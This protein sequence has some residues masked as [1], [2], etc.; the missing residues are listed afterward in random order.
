MAQ[1][2]NRTAVGPRYS[3]IVKGARKSF[4][5]I[6]N[7]GRQLVLALYHEPSVN[8]VILTLHPT[9]IAS[10]DII[11]ADLHG[12]LLNLYDSRLVLPQLPTRRLVI[13]LALDA[14]SVLLTPIRPI[15][16]TTSRCHQIPSLLF[17]TLDRYGFHRPSIAA[18]RLSSCIDTDCHHFNTMISISN[19][20]LA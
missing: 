8:A 18:T 13:L 17:T 20:C 12:S 11:E 15:L 7:H 19:E 9:R 2:S 1:T 3:E 4:P 16:L 6:R 5:A 14:V 10:L